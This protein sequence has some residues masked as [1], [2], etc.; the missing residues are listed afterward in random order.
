MPAAR[1]HGKAIRLSRTLRERPLDELPPDPRH[2]VSPRRGRIFADAVGPDLLNRVRREAL[3]A[4]YRV[5]AS[6]ASVDGHRRCRLEAPRRVTCEA[7]GRDAA[8]ADGRGQAPTTGVASCARRAT[9]TAPESGGRTWS[10]RDLASP[11]CHVAD[12]TGAASEADWPTA[13]AGRGPGGSTASVPPGRRLHSGRWPS[14]Y[15]EQLA[16]QRRSL[17]SRGD[18]QEAIANLDDAIAA[19]RAIEALLHGY[20]NGTNK[21]DESRQAVR[22]WYRAATDD[23]SPI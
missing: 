3:G 23:V 6:S 16:G 18:H 21:T 22:A 1:S 19:A 9:A 20:L 12:S 15:L 8:K 17:A 5:T 10:Q 14:E 4:G 11:D 13:A 7:C 2:L